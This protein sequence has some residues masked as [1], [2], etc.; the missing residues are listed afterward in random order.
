MHSLQLVCVLLALK[1]SRSVTRQKTSFSISFQAQNLPSLLFYLKKY[2]VDYFQIL[3][4][5]YKK[6]H[7]DVPFYHH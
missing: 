2:E 4:A 1:Y 3:P 6:V 7:K 5:F